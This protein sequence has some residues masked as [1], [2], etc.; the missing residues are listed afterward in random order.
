MKNKKV[1]ITGAG[2][3]IGSHLAELSIEMGYDVKALIHYNSQN[4]WGWLEDSAYKND[5]EFISGDVRDF[6][7]PYTMLYRIVRSY[8][9]S[10]P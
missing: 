5:I 9:T 1:F 10:Q 8:F 6:D 2:G 7:L 3:F 4:N